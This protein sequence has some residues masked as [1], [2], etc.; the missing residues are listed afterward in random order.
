MNRRNLIKGAGVIALYSS[1]P[2]VLSEF[3][4]SWKVVDKVLRLGFFSDEEFNL[5]EQV[6]DIILPRTS[7]PGALDTGVP[8]FIDLVKIKM[9]LTVFGQLCTC[10]LL[11]LFTCN[12]P[13]NIPYPIT[14]TF[15]VYNW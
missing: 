9:F 4:L 2:A 12:Q 11:S 6:S 15:R 1:F 14:G 13:L 5:L 8:F 10:L 3:L 7:T